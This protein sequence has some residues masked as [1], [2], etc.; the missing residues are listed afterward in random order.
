MGL[1]EKIQENVN[2]AINEYF[3]KQNLKEKKFRYP[4]GKKVG[5]SQKTKNYVTLI[6]LK[7]NG[8]IDYKKYQIQ[9]QT[10]IHDTIPRLANAGY[11]FH[12]KKN[13][14]VIIL[15]EWSVRPISA[16]ENYQL[17]LEDGSNINGYKILMAAMLRNKVDEKKKVGSWLAWVLGLIVVGVIIFALVSGGDAGVQ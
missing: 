16:A 5:K 10:I 6:L 9:D 12:D 11:V 8:R 15:P 17:S 1:D 3:E 13:N 2:K 7:D 4:F 14:P